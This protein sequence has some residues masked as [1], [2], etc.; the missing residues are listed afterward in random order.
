MVLDGSLS[1][2]LRVRLLPGTSSE[3]VK[4][5]AFVVISGQAG[6]YFSIVTDVVLG[7]VSED[8]LLLPPEGKLAREVTAGALTFV[9]L[10]V[11]PLLLVKSDG[12]AAPVKS[13][14]LH[15]SL[16]SLATAE[17]FASVFGAPDN[18]HFAI[19]SPLELPGVPVC[20]DLPKL[21]ERSNGIFGKSGTGKSFLTRLL[22]AGVIKSGLAS[23]LIF[24]IH[25]EYGWSSQSEGTREVKGLK[26]LF[27]QKVRI[28]SLDQKSSEER[29]V[30]PDAQVE[31]GLDDLQIEDILLLTDELN[32]SA[33]AGETAALL[34]RKFGPSWLS[35]LLDWDPATRADQAD[36]AGADERSV[37]A[38]QRKLLQIERLSFI[39]RGSSTKM[40]DEMLDQLER[41]QTVVLEFGRHRS[42][43]AYLLTANL[44]S[45][46]L[47]ARAVAKTERYLS[48]KHAA[49]KPQSVVIVLEEAHNFLKPSLAKQT[50]FGQIAREL[51]KYAVTLLIVDQRPSE[52]DR[53]VMSQI[54]TRITALLNDEA[55]I[56]AVFTGVAG[57]RLLRTVL[58]TLDSKQ[59]AL[60][61]GHALPLPVVIQTRAYDA[62]FYRDIG[63]TSSYRDIGATSPYRDIGATSAPSGEDAAAAHQE[64]SANE[65]SDKPTAAKLEATKKSLFPS[66]SLM[67]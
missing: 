52:I 13:L 54:G 53:E 45:R 18:S 36:F 8:V 43:L 60:L 51:R 3:E 63:A 66:D 50:I 31:L 6:D 67:D 65:E 59:Q 11:A 55:D 22:L 12:Q 9:L 39:K 41:G 24:D 58:S 25:N 40:I 30:A 32:L 61:L 33:T 2:G 56:D 26:Q 15:F 57:S 7:G 16:L 21:I 34:L 20:L 27:G 29:G 28:Y 1:E 19:G 5:G 14:P 4:V 35:D 42:T 49:A 64:I 23:V 46:R 47:Y 38:L 44:V 17:D 37:A 10:K 48:T 62:S